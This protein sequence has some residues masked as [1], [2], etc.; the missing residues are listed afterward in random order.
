MC[1]PKTSYQNYKH[2]IDSKLAK[3]M[4][5]VSIYG[6]FGVARGGGVFKFFFDFV[7]FFNT[8]MR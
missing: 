6:Y 2:N 7:I 8:T 4:Q 3:K 1:L 5:T